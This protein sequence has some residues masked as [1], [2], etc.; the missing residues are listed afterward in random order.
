M[1]CSLRP[2]VVSL[3]FISLCCSMLVYIILFV[4]MHIDFNK[5]IVR[6]LT[7][8]FLLSKIGTYEE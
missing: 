2:G 3:I 5:C 7:L 1:S 8:T 4:C 6:K